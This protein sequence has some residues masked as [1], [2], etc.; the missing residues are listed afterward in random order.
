[1]LIDTDSLVSM[2]DANQ[3]FS[4]V[5]KKVDEKGRVVVMKN[6]APKYVI[7][8][9]NPRE[10]IELIDEER[11]MQISREIMERNREAYEELAKH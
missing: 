10:E 9:F 1:M 6:N 3:N 2:T 5:A 4:K 7:S 8:R 11:I